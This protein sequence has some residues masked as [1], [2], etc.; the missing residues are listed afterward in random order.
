MFFCPV[1]C[2][3]GDTSCVVDLISFSRFD[4]AFCW[5]TRALEVFWWLVSSFLWFAKFCNCRKN[6]SCPVQPQLC[7]AVLLSCA[8]YAPTLFPLQSSICVCIVDTM[9]KRGIV[10]IGS[11]WAKVTHD[12]W[13]HKCQL[14]FS[15]LFAV[16]SISKRLTVA[17]FVVLF[18]TRKNIIPN[19][20]NCRQPCVLT[21]CWLGVSHLSLSAYAKRYIVQKNSCRK[22]LRQVNGNL[23]HNLTLCAR[24][25]TQI[26]FLAL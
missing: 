10:V 22:Q 12:S 6:C 18:F 24:S 8:F 5:I 15:N 19:Y 20:R 16:S 4:C 2:F 11:I 13:V 3:Y 23:S 7:C 17:L 25:W 1:L 9:K 14:F 21:W 26:L